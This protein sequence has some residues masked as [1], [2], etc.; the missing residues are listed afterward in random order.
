MSDATAR[1]AGPLENCPLASALRQCIK[2]TAPAWAWATAIEAGL[3]QQDSTGF[4][5]QEPRATQTLAAFTAY[6]EAGEP[7]MRE[8][9][10][11]RYAEWRGKNWQVFLY[12]NPLGEIGR[13]VIVHASR[14]RLLD[15]AAA[16]QAADE[17]ASTWRAEREQK[18][19]EQE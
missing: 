19:G 5:V 18:A 9:G 4:H 13:S 10:G 15:V 1:E 3:A 11:W 16:L 17:L 6:R 2:G 7:E 14:G 8:E 12:Q